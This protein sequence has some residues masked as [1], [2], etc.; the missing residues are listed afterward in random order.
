MWDDWKHENQE[1]EEGDQNRK[2]S[3]CCHEEQWETEP[4]SN[5]ESLME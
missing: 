5:N 1:L 4:E 3:Q 2:L